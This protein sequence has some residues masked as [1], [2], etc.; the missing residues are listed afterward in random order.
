MPFPAY[1]LDPIPSDTRS[2]INNDLVLKAIHDHSVMLVEKGISAE[3][4]RVINKMMDVVAAMLS[5]LV[6]LGI[7]LSP[8]MAR[9]DDGHIIDTSHLLAASLA[10]TA[11]NI[12]DY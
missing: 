10:D 8:A 9:A 2:I 4:K 5:E 3:S 12:L 11:L 7:D 6:D 1:P